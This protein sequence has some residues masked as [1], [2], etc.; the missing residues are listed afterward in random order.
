MLIKKPPIVIILGHVDHG[1]TTLLDNIRRS[2]IASKEAGGITQKIGA[3][4]ITFNREKIT[5]IDTPG[6]FAFSK[7]RERGVKVADIGVLV[8]AAD[9]GVK[10]QT[11]ESL[12]YLKAINLPFIVALNKIDKKEAEPQKVISQ[13]ME[14]EVIPEKFGGDMPFIEISAKNGQGITDL[15]E[16]IILLRDIHDLNVE[17][18]KQGQGFILETFKDDRRGIL[19]SVI[20]TEGKISLG[21]ILITTNSFSKIKILEDDLGKKINSAYPCQPVLVGNFDNFPLAGES[22]EIGDWEKIKE[23]QKR[24]EEKKEL[25]IR[26]YI[27]QETAEG[28]YLLII[29][30]DHFG[31]L[32]ALE[33]IFENLA[34]QKNIN[35][36][37][38]KADLGPLTHEDVKLAKDFRAILITFNLKNSK[39]ILEEIKNLQLSLLDSNII[40]EIE[41]KF[42]DLIQ[43]KN[44]K[45]SVNGELEVLAVFNQSKTKKTIGGRV[46]KYKIKLNQKILIFRGEEII[47]RGKIISLEENKISKSEV[48]EGRL[49]GLIVETEQE[50]KEGDI[51]KTE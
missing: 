32:E 5:F 42:F 29:K 25:F 47:G 9:E 50:I 40:Y 35:L 30:A 12:E 28:D 21:D 3:Y 10:P 11:R 31:S 4:E 34:H 20:V 44:I 51:L 7:L 33:N 43:N 39:V 46:I 22:F 45:E 17:T 14:L 16:T 36:K 26:K 8:V 23:V 49:C 6:H 15:L 41:E 18:E 38:I 13:L 24:L 2:N 19:A 37:I 1:K 48:E 27:F